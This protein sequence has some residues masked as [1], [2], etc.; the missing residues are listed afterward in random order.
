MY[1][2]FGV[3]SGASLLLVTLAG[4]GLASPPV[5]PPTEGF[6]IATAVD[7]EMSAGDFSETEGFTG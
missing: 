5:P 2:T 6:G 4:P 1:S 3:I 7:C